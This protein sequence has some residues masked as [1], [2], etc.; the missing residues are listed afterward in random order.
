M[1]KRWVAEQTRQVDWVTEFKGLARQE[2]ERR[3]SGIEWTQGMIDE[4]RLQA[5]TSDDEPPPWD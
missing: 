2:N 1:G 3:K 5:E 4:R